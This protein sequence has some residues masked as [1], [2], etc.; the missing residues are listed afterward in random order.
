FALGRSALCRLWSHPALRLGGPLRH[1]ERLE[2]PVAE[3]VRLVI[4][5][6]RQP[7][8]GHRDGALL[9]VIEPSLAALG[10][11]GRPRRLV[12]LEVEHA[13][14]DEGI[15][16]PAPEDA[17]PAEHPPHARSLDLPEEFLELRFNCHGPSLRLRRLRYRIP[18]HNTKRHRFPLSSAT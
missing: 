14:R 12:A 2:G 1:G 13:A 7:P 15:H 18:I 9:A 17:E 4:E 10:L 3:L 8:V 5:P 6:L 11:E 16:Q